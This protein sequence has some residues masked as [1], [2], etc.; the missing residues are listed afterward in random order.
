MEKKPRKIS[1]IGSRATSILSVALVLIVLGLCGLLAIAVTRASDQ[2]SDSTTLLV[3][4]APGTDPLEVSALK[5]EFNDAPWVEKYDFTDAKTVLQRESEQMDRDSHLALDL[6]PENPF[7]DEFAIRIAP[8]YRSA[9]SLA[10]LTQRLHDMPHVD[11]VAGNATAVGTSNDGIKSLLIYLAILAAALMLVSI[12]L[13][14]NTISLSIY[15]RRFTINT[16][17]LVGATPAFIRRPFVRAGTVT[18]II[19]G[20]IA[21]AVI[22]PLQT[23]VM[24]CEP[25]VGP[26]ITWIDIIVSGAGLVVL[27]TLIARFAAWRAASIY[28]R[29]TYDQLFKK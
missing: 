26:Y 9:D 5:R 6:L 10:V 15:S 29:K 2:I 7:G 27:G 24:L 1:L 22:C 11:I 18:G 28:L 21:A 4:I 14:T 17:K 8:D 12:A 19:A 25:L 13:I 23:Y 3:T 20:L 16:M